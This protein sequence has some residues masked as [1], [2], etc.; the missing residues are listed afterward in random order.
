MTDTDTLA[1]EHERPIPP[2]SICI[3]IPSHDGRIGFTT[4]Q[5]ILDVFVRYQRVA[6]FVE[7]GSF[8]PKL[9]DALTRAGIE[10]G[11][12]YVLM[13]DS[14]MVFS[15]ANVTALLALEVDLACGAYVSRDGRNR[16]M[17]Q[18]IEDEG[19]PPPR[20]SMGGAGNAGC[21]YCC[22]SESD[23]ERGCPRNA[24]DLEHEPLRKELASGIQVRWAGAGFLLFRRAELERFANESPPERVYIS[25]AAQVPV[26]ALWTADLVGGAN[27]EHETEDGAFMRRWRQSGRSIWIGTTLGHEGVQTYHPTTAQLAPQRPKGAIEDALP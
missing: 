22:G 4:L 11:A 18:R 15:A 13:V 1:E 7:Q 20:R 19:Q 5:G 26:D 14:D 16:P 6:I 27:L 2:P 9:R 21:D 25:A 24:R 23:H 12:D 10:S 17:W 8:L 3:C